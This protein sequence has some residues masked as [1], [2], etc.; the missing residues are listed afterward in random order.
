LRF[1]NAA[2]FRSVPIYLL[3][4]TM[5]SIRNTTACIA[6]ACL[7]LGALA[8]TDAE[9][10]QHHPEAPAKSAPKAA[11][12]TQQMGMMADMDK[13]M[14]SMRDMHEKMMNAKTQEDRN[15]LMTDHMKTMQ[16]GMSMMGNMGMSSKGKNAKVPMDM[17]TR[18]M[19]MEK[20]MDMMQGMMQMMMDRMPVPAAK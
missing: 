16:D 11:V 6:I 10:A 1:G 3:E 12:K 14:D 19:M 17:A 15:T 13:Q 8:Q 9:N 2:H 20:R 5:K 18:Q 7:S 4:I